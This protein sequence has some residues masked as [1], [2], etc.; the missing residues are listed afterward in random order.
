MKMARF[1]LSMDYNS[2]ELTPLVW[3]LG[4][5][6]AIFYLTAVASLRFR[7][8]RALEAK[9]SQYLRDPH[10]MDYKTAHEIITTSMLVEFPFSFGFSLQWA[11]I[12][13]YAI[14]NG[15][16]L[17]VRTRRL[18]DEKI[19]GKRGEDTGIILYVR[20]IGRLN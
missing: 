13:S 10:L 3:I 8:L 12:K 4:A 5:A 20:G 6:T 7:N 14:A 2:I 1:N 17:L 9:Y 15:T 16:Q 11:L 18:T 19:V